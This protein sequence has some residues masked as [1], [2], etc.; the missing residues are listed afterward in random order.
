LPA[1]VERSR[2]AIHDAAAAADYDALEELVL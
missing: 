1:A 2:A